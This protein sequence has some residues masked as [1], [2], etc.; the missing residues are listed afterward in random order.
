MSSRLSFF[1]LVL[2][3]LHMTHGASSQRLLI[4]QD[5]D[6]LL[7]SVPPTY[8][9]PAAATFPPETEQPEPQTPPP[10]RFDPN[11]TLPLLITFQADFDVI[12][13]QR[14][15]F[16]SRLRADLASILRVRADDIRVNDIYKGSVVVDMNVF[17]DTDLRQDA[18][19]QSFIEK[20]TV[21]LGQSFRD[22][23]NITGTTVKFNFKGN[24]T[25]ISGASTNA[26][27]TK[28]FMGAMVAVT[29]LSIFGL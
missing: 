10:T 14:L 27:L 25:G 23:F 18:T 20:P 16:E 22:A 29:C 13:Q 7:Q 19:V 26:R 1:L 24:D 28:L 21:W 2:P 3:I 15:E 4:S 8:P 11:Y 17:A 9:P 6:V 5:V 12:I